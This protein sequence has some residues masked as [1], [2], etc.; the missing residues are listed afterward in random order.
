M[1]QIIFH[2]QPAWLIECTPEL[3]LQNPNALDVSYGGI[4]YLILLK[5]P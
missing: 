4:A 5:K 1:T 3:L 2:N